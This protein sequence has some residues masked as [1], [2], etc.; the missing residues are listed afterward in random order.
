VTNIHSKPPQSRQENE[1]SRGMKFYDQVR[2]TKREA[3]KKIV[4]RFLRKLRL[5][6][7]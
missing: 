1:L 7:K 4:E 6:A 3:R 5:K 2:S